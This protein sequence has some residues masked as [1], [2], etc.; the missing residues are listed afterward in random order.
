VVF[1]AWFMLVI[2][3]MDVPPLVLGHCQ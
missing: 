2:L 1:S 3:A